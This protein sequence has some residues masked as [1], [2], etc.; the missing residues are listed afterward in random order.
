MTLPWIKRRHGVT[1]TPQA[2]NQP[3]LFYVREFP[4]SVDS[5]S[6]PW[7]DALP[8][9]GGIRSK[10]DHFI[11][12]TIPASISF[13]SGLVRQGHWSRRWLQSEA[14]SLASSMASSMFFTRNTEATG[15]KNSSRYAGESWE[16][17]PAPLA[18][19]VPGRSIGRPP[20]GARA[21]APIVSE[22]GRAAVS[23]RPTSSGPSSVW[24]SIGLLLS[25][26]YSVDEALLEF[27][28]DRLVQ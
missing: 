1:T 6:R 3:R 27:I 24:G 7:P 19:V 13:Q 4:D 12:N 21:P 2:T 11:V 18:H 14:E 8:P 28:G 22:P 26:A 9:N 10:C 23:P 15:P 5:S 25:T 20:V 16:C 17:R